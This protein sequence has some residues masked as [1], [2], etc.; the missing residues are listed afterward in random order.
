[1]RNI[2]LSAIL[3]DYTAGKIHRN[4]HSKYEGI[5]LEVL[6]DFHR[7]LAEARPESVLSAGKVM[8]LVELMNSDMKS[9]FNRN[10]FAIYE[11]LIQGLHE[12]LNHAPK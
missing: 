5:V 11:L 3:K 1:M 6:A 4:F 12:D 2:P 7:D 10:P 8:K 9:F